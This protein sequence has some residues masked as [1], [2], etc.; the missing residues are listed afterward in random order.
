MATNSNRE[1]LTFVSEVVASSTDRQVSRVFPISA[2]DSECITIDIL[3]RDAVV[4]NAITAKLQSC[5]NFRE[6]SSDNMWITHD[7]VA[8]TGAVDTLTLKT[9]DLN[10][11]ISGDQSKLPIRP[12][13][14]VVV[15][16]G[17]GDTVTLESIVA[18]RRTFS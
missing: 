8:I 17:V 1:V 11:A 16:T 13:A 7:T 2:L 4:T 3:Y 12:N 15:T 14:R 10:I 5:P 6:G 9:I 18:S